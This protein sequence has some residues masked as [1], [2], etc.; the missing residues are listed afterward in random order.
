[1][2][3]AGGE[4]VWR[5]W[6]RGQPL[7]SGKQCKGPEAHSLLGDAV[8]D[9]RW[10]AHIPMTG[11]GQWCWGTGPGRLGDPPFLSLGAGLGEQTFRALRPGTWAWEMEV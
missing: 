7:P 2:A 1:M 4:P 11:S 9:G 5:I 10:G 8:C 6:P 3:G